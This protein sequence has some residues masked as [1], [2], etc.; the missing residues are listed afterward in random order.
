MPQ[1]TSTSTLKKRRVTNEV[2]LTITPDDGDEQNTIPVVIPSTEETLA[3]MA[4]KKEIQ[5]EI[6]TL[7]QDRDPFDTEMARRQRLL[8][9]LSPVPKAA[10]RKFIFAQTLL[11]L[12]EGQNVIQVQMSPVVMGYIRTTFAI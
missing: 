1:T 9:S 3:I 2:D 6:Q 11:R 5:I 8:E 7:R 4:R 12:M 10:M